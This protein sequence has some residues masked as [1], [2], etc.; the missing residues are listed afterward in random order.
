[1]TILRRRAAFALIL[2]LAGC[3]GDARDEGVAQ[4][5]TLREFTGCGEL[6]AYIRERSLREMNAQIDELIRQGPPGFRGGPVPTGPLPNGPVAV[7]APAPTPGPTDF[8]TTNTQER[9]VDEPDFV[10]NDG[11][12]IFVLHGNAL[13]ETAAWPP[14]QARIRGAT[15]LEGADGQMLL[16][17]N[18]AAVFSPADIGPAFERA[19][20]AVD[21]GDR[22]GP[23]GYPYGYPT[24]QKLT[25]L[26]VSSAPGRVL[27]ELYV[28]GGYVT[29][30]RVGPSIR[31]VTTGSLRAPLLKF[32]PEDPAAWRNESAWRSALEDIR[33]ANAAAIRAHP[34]EKW[35]PRMVEA[36]DGG[37][38]RALGVECGQYR[39]TSGPVALGWST[40]STIHLGRLADGARHT[41]ILNRTDAVYASRDD[42]Y[43]T[44]SHWWRPGTDGGAHTYVHAFDIASDPLRARYVASG[45]V[46]GQPL[47]QFSMDEDRGA[48]RLATTR[49]AFD[50]SGRATT[51]NDVY[52]LRAEGGRLRVVGEL[53]GLAAGERIFSARFEGPRGYVVTFRQVDPLF[54]LDLSDPSRPRAVGELKVPGFSTYLHPMGEDDILAIGREVVERPQGPVVSG[55]ALQVFD[56]SDFANPRLLHKH[57]LGASG[58][59]SD[60]L[61]DH[62]AFNFFAARALLGIPYSDWGGPGRAFRSSLDVFRVTAAGGIAPLGSVDHSDLVASGTSSGHGWSPYVRRSVMID[63]FVYSISSGGIKVSSVGDFRSVA[64]VPFP[65]LPPQPVFPLRLPPR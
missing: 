61:Y 58:S 34:M 15:E 43:V 53:K 10:K 19:G 16:D 57:V 33:A 26:D 5:V 55:V 65:P 38:P 56:V 1:V 27:Y 44:Q 7:P 14:D 48:F 31:M 37:A 21:G 47:N 20:L 45:G 39:A 36:F 13:I 30:R 42:L 52:V 49:T 2:A 51:S 8:T 35:L 17:G 64:V 24:G 60:A 63:D 62:K 3:G 29:A 46:A 18:R 54:T 12:R 25:V 59:S 11:R 6:E 50:P 40:V 22:P 28:E 23:Y 32:Y 4:D 41:S 9:G